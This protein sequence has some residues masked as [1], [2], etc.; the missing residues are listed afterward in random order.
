MTISAGRLRER[1]TIQHKIVSG[2]DAKGADLF[3]WT[4]FAANLP[5]QVEPLAGREFFAAD[6]AQ[7]SVD[8]RVRIRYLDGITPAM[9]LMWDGR[10]HD[11]DSVIRPNAGRIFLELMCISGVHDGR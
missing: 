1:V 6:Q 9:R 10:A 3:V 7:S 5:A 4:D 11:I 8:V 2:K